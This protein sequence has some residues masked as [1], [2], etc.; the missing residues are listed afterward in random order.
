[1]FT[2]VCPVCLGLRAAPFLSVEGRD[3]WR[4]ADCLAT[5]LDR[6]SLP[7][8]EAETA[9]YH[10]HRN[11]ADDP[12][13]I[14]HLSRLAGPMLERLAPGSVGLD[15][16][17]GPSDA[18]AG[19]FTAAGH[20]VRCY[21]PLFQP[22]RSP[23][24]QAYDFIALAEVAEHFHDP[25]SEFDRLAR[26]LQPGG[27]LGVMTRLLDDDA[28]FASWRYRRDFTHVVFYKRRTFESLAARHGWAA[29]FPVPD[30][31]LMRS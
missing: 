15:Y 27:L 20:T 19:L 18:L 1:M 14:A 5:F 3:Y 31:A 7:D 9:R 10:Q 4:C 24:D 23:L 22:D 13:Y 8:R 25:H 11:S 26:L 28:G 30:V 21:D 16:G 12:G 29:D 6:A 2:E 17:C